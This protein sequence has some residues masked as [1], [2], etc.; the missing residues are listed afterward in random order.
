VSRPCL[1]EAL[2]DGLARE[3]VLVCHRR[4]GGIP[5]GEPVTDGWSSLHEYVAL[6]LGEL[7]RELGRK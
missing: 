2:S 7:R 6:R 4:F 1:A 3:L 5:C